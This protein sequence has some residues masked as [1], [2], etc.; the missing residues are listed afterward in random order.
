LADGLLLR[1]RACC[2]SLP[3]PAASATSFVG[4]AEYVSPE[5][6][7]NQPLSYPADLW[8]LGCLLFQMITGEGCAAAPAW[9]AFPRGR[10]R[11]CALGR[12]STCG[13]LHGCV[14][15]RA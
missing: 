12:G 6:L 5:V 2:P 13:V 9:R 3:C 1:A 15:R 14:G 4:T 8:A 11:V 7:L 10:G